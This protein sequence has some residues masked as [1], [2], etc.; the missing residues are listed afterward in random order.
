MF[1]DLLTADELAAKLRIR[2]RKVGELSK[3]GLIPCV[4]VS[5]KARRFNFADVL[6]ALQRG[7]H[8]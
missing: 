7:A 2:P 6:R 5:R 3:A 8:E 4:E 1:S